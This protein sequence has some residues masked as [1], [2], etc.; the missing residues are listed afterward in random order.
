MKQR[1]LSQEQIDQIYIKSLHGYTERQIAKQFNVSHSTIKRAVDS[2]VKSHGYQ[3]SLATIST[4]LEQ[5]QRHGD[6]LTN[7]VREIEDMKNGVDIEM[8]LELM[9]AQFKRMVALIE[10]A[11]QGK[12]VLALRDLMKDEVNRDREGNKELSEQEDS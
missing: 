12:L 3:L 2:I 8:K 11:G 1:K 6:F 10:K 7:Q 9:D 4:F 5:F